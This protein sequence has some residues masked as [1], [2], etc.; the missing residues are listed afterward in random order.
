MKPEQPLKMI[1]VLIVTLLLPATTIAASVS[2]E[3]ITPGSEREAL[4]YYQSLT[5]EFGVDTSSTSSLTGLISFAGYPLKAEQL[6]T[7]DPQVLMNTNSVSAC[8]EG[9]PC[10]SA[11][12]LAG[13]NLRA[14]DILAARFFAPK[15]A[16][17]AT[18]KPT[19][20]WRKLVRLRTRPDSAASKT[21]IESVVILFNFFGESGAAAY[22]TRS[23]NTQVMLLAPSRKNRLYWM[24]FDTQG[25]LS[26]ALD[27]FFDAGLTGCET[28]KYF[29]PNGCNA[30]HGSPGNLRPPMVNYLD[31]DHWF[32][33]LND[34]F[35]GV[36]DPLL[37]DAGTNDPTSPEFARAMDV[38]RQFNEE[39][40][41]QN[42]LV[43]H[44]SFET[45]TARKWLEIHSSKDS[46]AD[47][48]D[49]GISIG[50]ARTWKDSEKNGLRM[51]N[52]FCFRCHGSVRF[53]VFDRQAVVDRSGMIR[54]RLTPSRSQG[55]IP[56][57]KMPP[58]RTLSPQEIAEL[59]A[60]LKSLE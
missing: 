41:R 24:D 58:D 3:A 32:D 1:A 21:G 9:G 48:I 5:S 46:H 47:I 12:G 10:V 38:I 55:K 7:L 6:E 53:S 43:H 37:F 4:N 33:R 15:I 39:A 34:D 14:G 54:Q 23:A 18:G 44:D 56:G 29:V 11:R 20:G 52:Q 22:K 28:R 8:N 51:L 60:F 42:N 35:A 25:K 30:C 57:F 31:T 19:P 50:G 59:D 45:Q 16:C 40:L 27:A 26:L 49:R 13:A 36:T 2:L 17:V